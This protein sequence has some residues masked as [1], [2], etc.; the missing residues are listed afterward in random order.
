MRIYKFLTL[1]C[2]L[3][4]SFACDNKKEELSA[5]NLTKTEVIPSKLEIIKN[6]LVSELPL[7]TR[8]KVNF[9][10]ESLNI[11]KE[12][13]F[14]TNLEIL[15]ELFS[16]KKWQEFE[17]QYGLFFSKLSLPQKE[18][19]YETTVKEIPHSPLSVFD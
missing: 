4:T 16:K 9:Q 5:V 13:E 8:Q 10:L 14:Q 18:Q 17:A 19:F 15:K 2:L 6:L 11:S 12:E 1:A 7:E 3:S